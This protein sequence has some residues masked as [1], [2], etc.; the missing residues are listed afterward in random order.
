VSFKIDLNYIGIG[1]EIVDGFSDPNN[2]TIDERCVI[3]S[4]RP[5]TIGDGVHSRNNKHEIFAFVFHVRLRSSKLRVY[6]FYI[7]CEWPSINFALR[8][9]VVLMPE[10][11]HNPEAR[12]RANEGIEKLVLV[13]VVDVSNDGER[14]NGEF[15]G[16]VAVRLYE[17]GSREEFVSCWLKRFSLVG[18]GTA[19]PNRES[20]II[21]PLWQSRGEFVF[22]DCPQGVIQSASQVVDDIGKYEGPSY[23]RR[24]LVLFDGYT[25]A[26]KLGIFIDMVRTRFSL[27]P[28]QDFSVESVEQFHSTVYLPVS[29]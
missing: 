26:G 17:I 16:G 12:H 9:L 22:Q 27:E 19:I 4:I 24:G 6:D 21:S 23:E 29:T 28:S 15:G 8:D 13:P 11:N 25:Y 10:T 2:K 18:V 5:E 14:M 20:E 7:L 3:I 1:D